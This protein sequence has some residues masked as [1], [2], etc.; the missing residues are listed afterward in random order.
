MKTNNHQSGVALVVAMIMLLVATLIGLAS[1][2]NTTLQERMTANLLDRSVAFQ[3]T[4]SALRA[5]EIAI[6]TSAQAFSDIYTD[7]TQRNAHDC[8]PL[9]PNPVICRPFPDNTWSRD[10]GDNQGWVNITSLP[11]ITSN[12]LVNRDLSS[13]EPQVYIQLIARIE[14]KEDTGQNSSANEQQY[15]SGSASDEVLYFRIT[16]RS[17]DPALIN[18]RALVVLQSIIKRSR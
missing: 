6:S 2:R 11:N 3:N 1:I 18:E 10:V 8:D 15:G 5:A 7:A 9:R 13:G 12:F 4:E 14:N 16:A 17:G